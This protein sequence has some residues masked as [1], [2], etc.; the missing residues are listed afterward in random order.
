MS[1]FESECIRYYRKVLTGKAAHFCLDWDDLPI[2]ETCPEYECC[3]CG[4]DVPYAGPD[5]RRGE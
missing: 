1:E 3:T 2:D 5:W 4:F